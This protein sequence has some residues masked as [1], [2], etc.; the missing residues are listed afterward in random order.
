MHFKLEGAEGV[1]DA[2]NGIFD[3]V[4]K[5]IHGIDMIGVAGMMMLGVFDA[6]DGRIA[7]MQ[8]GGCH[9]DPGA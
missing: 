7:H 6:V 3:A 2:F 5:V 1:G 4:S 8:V 9:V